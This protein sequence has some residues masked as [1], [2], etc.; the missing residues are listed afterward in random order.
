MLRIVIHLLRASEVQIS[1]QGSHRSDWRV[2]REL[3]DE[4]QW[5]HALIHTHLVDVSLHHVRW[6][7]LVHISG[8]QGNVV[9]HDT[10]YAVSRE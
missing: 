7:V 5:Q 4:V 6:R 3:L 8:T 1:L 9:T 10:A 2:V